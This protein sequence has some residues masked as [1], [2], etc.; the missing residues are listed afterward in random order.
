MYIHVL[1]HRVYAEYMVCGEIQSQTR[2]HTDMLL[3]AHTHT[4]THLKSICTHIH[5]NTNVETQIKINKYAYTHAHTKQKHR[6]THRQ[7]PSKLYSLCMDVCAKRPMLVFIISK[8]PLPLNS[9]KHAESVVIESNTH[10]Q[11]HKASGDTHPLI[12]LR[13]LK[14]EPTLSSKPSLS[15]TVP[16]T[17]WKNIPEAIL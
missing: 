5:R 17:A 1:W 3:Q 11:T 14:D 13:P 8:G 2:T 10:T 16:K 4:H 7:D 6:P 9:Q 15:I 12:S